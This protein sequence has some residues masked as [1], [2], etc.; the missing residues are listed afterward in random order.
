MMVNNQ[1]AFIAALTAATLLTAGAAWAADQQKSTPQQISADKDFAKLS[2]DGSRAFQD[3]M[4]TRMAI[5]DGRVDEAKEFVNNADAAFAK[6]RSDEAIFTKAEADLK[7]PTT[8]AAPTNKSVTTGAAPADIKQADQ[9]KKPIAWLPVDG[10]ITIIEDYTANPAKTAAVADANKSLKSGDRKGAMEKL[11]LADMN[12]EVTLAVIP[13]EQTINSVHQAV[14]LINDGKYYEASQVLR[15]AQ[16]NE[17]FDAINISAKPSSVPVLA[18]QG[19][20]DRSQSQG[21]QQTQAQPANTS[22]QIS[23]RHFSE[24]EVRKIQL[25][26]DDKGF[27]SGKVD[28]SWGPETE[29]AFKDFQKWAMLSPTGEVDPISI[30]V[31][32]LNVTDFGLAGQTNVPDQKK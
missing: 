13:L 23:P 9:M 19:A 10:M 17:R 20:T 24:S 2:A 15:Q 14:G 30:A 3:L 18:Q 28:G 8:K 26:L 7:P 21:R 32:G 27:K 31:L 25:A 12:V 16:D 1:K 4:L 22:G 11:K 6:V 5:F 29:A